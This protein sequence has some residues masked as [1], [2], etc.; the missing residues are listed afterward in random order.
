MPMRQALAMAIIAPLYLG[1]AAAAE[2]TALVNRETAACISSA[3]WREY[4]QASLTRRGARVSDL[5][6]IR[7]PARTR[8]T[9]V[10]EDAGHGASEI[11]HIG[12][13][14]FIDEQQLD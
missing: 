14:W 8:V 5:C 10:D 13:T 2:R 7:I 6:P 4:V 3:A 9:V 11:R 1:A 12:K